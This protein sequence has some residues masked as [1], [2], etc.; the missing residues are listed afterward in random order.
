MRALEFL[1]LEPDLTP[2]KLKRV[3]KMIMCEEKHPNVKDVLIGEYRKTPVFAGFKKF[4]LVSTIEKLMNNALHRYYSNNDP[5]SAVVKLFADVINIHPFEDGNGRLSQVILSHVLS[6]R[7]D[8][9][10]FLYS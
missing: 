2:E 8:V 1:Q 9:A 3:H 6:A 10:C 7:T 4:A 5:I